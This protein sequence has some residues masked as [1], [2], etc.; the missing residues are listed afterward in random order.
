MEL[1]GIANLEMLIDKGWTELAE[2]GQINGRTLRDIQDQV[3]VL[4][5]YMN[6][7]FE[8]SKQNEALLLGCGA[9]PS[10]PPYW[11]EVRIKVLGE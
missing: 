11:H 8:A 10:K 5:Q 3:R 4:H 6:A 2:N 1:N 7:V 9:K